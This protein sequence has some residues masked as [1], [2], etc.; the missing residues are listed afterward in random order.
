MATMSGPVLLTIKEEEGPANDS[1][2]NLPAEKLEPPTESFS[3]E[4]DEI[5]LEMELKPMGAHSNVE[6]RRYERAFLILLFDAFRKG[7]PCGILR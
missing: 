1:K 3:V 4:G 2:L 7:F 5:I 6:I